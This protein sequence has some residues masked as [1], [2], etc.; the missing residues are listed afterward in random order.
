Q[1]KP[2]DFEPYSDP[3]DDGDNDYPG[4]GRDSDADE[5]LGPQWPM[6]NPYGQIPAFHL[7]TDLDYGKPVHRNAFALQDAISKLIEMQMV[8][9]EFSGYP[10][11]YAIQEADSLGNQSIREDPLADNSPA[12]WDHDFSE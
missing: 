7:R 1:A 11:R 8:T 9:V 5:V 3:D 4:S 6:P 2:A 12:S 10:Q